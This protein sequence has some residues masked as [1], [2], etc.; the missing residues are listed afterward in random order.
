MGRLGQ[1]VS[2][3]AKPT[4]D[5]TR[6]IDRTRQCM[7]GFSSQFWMIWAES[8][9]MALPHQFSAREASRSSRVTLGC[10]PSL[11]LRNEKKPCSP[12]AKCVVWPRQSAHSSEVAQPVADRASPAIATRLSLR[13]LIIAVSSVCV[14][15]GGL[16]REAQVLYQMTARLAPTLGD[17]READGH[18]GHDRIRK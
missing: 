4:A 18:S 10:R 1:P 14:K 7:G 15:P 8:T 9:L 17:H 11:S 16:P 3:T 5:S 2:S 13:M 6:A 12:E